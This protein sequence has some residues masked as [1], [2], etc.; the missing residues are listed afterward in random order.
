MKKNT[1]AIIIILSLIILSLILELALVLDFLP[2]SKNDPVNRVV[3]KVVVIKKIYIKIPSKRDTIYIPAQNYIPVT[4]PKN[5]NHYK[6]S[7]FIHRP[8]PVC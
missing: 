7:R 6:K 2:K 1:I 5:Q 4:K 3:K 8:N